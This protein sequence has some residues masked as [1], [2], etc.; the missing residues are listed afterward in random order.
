MPGCD[1]LGNL[2]QDSESKGRDVNCTSEREN[3][4]VSGDSKF[5]E[6]NQSSIWSCGWSCGAPQPATKTFGVPGRGSLGPLEV[7]R[8]DPEQRSPE[9]EV[10]GRRRPASQHRGA[11]EGERA[12]AE[13]P[14]LPRIAIVGHV[15]RIRPDG[16]LDVIVEILRD[17]ERIAVVRPE[18]V[19]AGG[20]GE[21]L[22]VRRFLID[23]SSRQRQLREDPAACDLVVAHDRIPLVFRL[24]VPA[25]VF[26]DAVSRYGPELARSA[27]VV[28][29]QRVVHPLDVIER[30]RRAIRIGGMVVYSPS[31]FS[32]LA[33]PSKLSTGPRRDPPPVIPTSDASG[34]SL[35]SRLLRGGDTSLADELNTIGGET[36]GSSAAGELAEK[37]RPGSATPGQP[38][39][40]VG[41][42]DASPNLMLTQTRSRH[43][44]LG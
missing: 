11:V 8:Q 40:Y 18:R 23:R 7:G 35:V 36:R 13:R 19:R 24:A 9:L 37:S 39:M 15:V 5:T 3:V 16:E 25:K 14:T 4:D 20:D 42:V 43:L 6:N 32:S 2:P 34:D 33:I 31:T 27:L 30:A 10:D 12:R 44:L 29:R 38:R 21:T 1:T 17:L 41:R 22:Q 26:P 28:H